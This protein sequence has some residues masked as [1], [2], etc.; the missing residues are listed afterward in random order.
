MNKNSNNTYLSIGDTKI[1]NNGTVYENPQDTLKD[2][3]K[4]WMYE[5]KTD[6]SKIKLKNEILDAYLQKLHT[7]VIL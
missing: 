4:S 2:P 1:N 5:I 3:D 6:L 7:F